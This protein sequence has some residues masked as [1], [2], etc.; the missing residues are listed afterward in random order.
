MSRSSQ[1]ISPPHKNINYFVLSVGMNSS[2]FNGSYRVHNL[3]ENPIFSPTF[4]GLYCLLP[5][6]MLQNLV[7]LIL[8]N[9]IISDIN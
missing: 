7:L 1:E 9:I 8:I 6:W 4:A 5:Q 3:S 2:L